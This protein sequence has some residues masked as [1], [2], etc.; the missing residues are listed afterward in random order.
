M[1]GR[2]E[3]LGIGAGLATA[4]ALALRP[5]SAAASALHRAPALHPA[6]RLRAGD[7]VGLIEPAGFT[8]GPERIEMVKQ[9]I[10]GMG[11]VPRLGAHVGTQ[12]G[13]LAGTDAERAADV[14]AMY[15]DH[16]VRA[17]FAVRGGWG[18]ER[19][20][21][22]LDWDTIRAHPKLL[23]GFSDITALHLAFAARAHFATIHGP[24]ASSSWP[25]VSWESLWR[26]GFSGQTPALD[27]AREGEPLTVL[28]PGTARGR[29]LGG[30]LAVLTA[31]VGTPWLPDFTGAILFLEEVRE[32]EY[33]VDRMLSQLQLS[34]VLG[35]L[36]GVVFG[37]CSHCATEE[38]DYVGFTVAQ[39]LEQYF[40]PLGVPAVSGANIGHVY[41]QI[42]LPSGAQVELDTAAGTLRLLEPIV[43]EQAPKEGPGAG[44]PRRDKVD[45]S[46]R[47]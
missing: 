42:C 43:G 25:K 35:K 34:G 44:Y 37:Q 15:A 1:I 39:V 47:R 13:Y 27:L 7:T 21:P 9:T 10:A 17:I 38:A 30:N 4:L 46:G 16:D 29:L 8:E 11:L 26:M 5:L 41:G 24:V 6:L 28:H 36:S 40:A 32:A 18:C 33:R 2:R 23:I 3:V 31:L 20:L 45:R 22:L 19:I 12:F 14:N